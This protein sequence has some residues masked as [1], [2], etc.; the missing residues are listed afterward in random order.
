MVLPWYVV[1]PVHA[2]SGNTLGHR[3]RAAEQHDV[4]VAGQ[5]AEV[6]EEPGTKETT[7][8]KNDEFQPVSGQLSSSEKVNHASETPEQH[9]DL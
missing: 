4:S 1:L 6:A 2:I 5:S 8:M 3:Q 7:D 9:V